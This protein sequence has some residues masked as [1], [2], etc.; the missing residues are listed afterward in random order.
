MLFDRENQ[1]WQVY[2]YKDSQQINWTLV[3]K[4]YEAFAFSIRF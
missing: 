4:M 1:N 2:N 3:A